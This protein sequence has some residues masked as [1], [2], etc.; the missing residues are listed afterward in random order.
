M[1]RD[2]VIC[3][4]GQI[5]LMPPHLIHPASRPPARPPETPEDDKIQ[6][7]DGLEPAHILPELHLALPT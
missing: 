5:R 6:S 4:D 2:D 1:V 3:D 7:N